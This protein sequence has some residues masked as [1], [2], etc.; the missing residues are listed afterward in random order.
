ME[1][2]A[3]FELSVPRYKELLE[4]GKPATYFVIA[5]Q[6]RAEEKWEVDR[7]YREFNELHDSLKKTHANLPSLPGKSLFS[8]KD[9]NDLETRRAGLEKYLRTIITRQDIVNNEAL[10]RFLHLDN[11]APETTVHPPKDIGELGG[12]V[13]GVRDFCYEPEKGLILVATSDMS[14]TSRVDSYLTNMK[15]PWEKE[16]QKGAH[17]TVG[18]VEC[19]VQQDLSTYKFEKLWTKTFQVQVICLYWEP[20]SNLLAVGQDDGTITV[21]KVLADINYIK[22]DEV[23]TNKVHAQ[24]VMGVYLD[25]TTGLCYSVSEDKKLKVFDYTK[26]DVISEL[27]PSSASLTGMHVHVETKRAFFTNRAG[28]SFI[29][30]LS[31]TIPKQIYSIQNH[32]KGDIRGLDFDIKTNYLFT[33]NMD[34]G[35][36]AIF[37]IGK[38]GKEKYASSRAMLLGKPKV[39]TCKWASNRQELISG[40]QDGTVT[41]W[42]ARKAEQIYVMHAHQD[43]ITQMMWLDK[44]QVLMTASKDKKI[45][46]WKLPEEWRDKS[47]VE[48]EEREY[49]MAKQ[50]ESMIKFKAQQEKAEL[51]SEEDD[52]AGW[53]N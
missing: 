49:I 29:Y 15:M 45:K 39:R 5:I 4:G 8:L 46:F 11:F 30:D 20:V 33:A 31:T 48:K 7:R 35:V 25:S 36:I 43:A 1:K 16:L 53:Q 34:D 44:T 41:F 10:K 19:Y 12:M 14:V 28:Q 42:D 50:T 38:P 37:D 3:P 22:Y 47:V 24:R 21:L 18:T 32:P 52:L 6:K 9:H 13:Y 23:A 17:V 40:N 27:S 2:R 26:N 51:D